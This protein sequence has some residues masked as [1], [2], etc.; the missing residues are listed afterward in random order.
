M[1]RKLSTLIVLAAVLAIS[2]VALAEGQH[3]TRTGQAGTALKNTS[4]Q[5]RERCPEIIKGVIFYRHKTWDKQDLLGENRTKKSSQYVWSM[6]CDYAEWVRKGWK[7]RNEIA[8]KEVERR[9]L[10]NSNDWN[11][12]IRIVQRAFPGTS[13]WMWSCSGAEGGHGEWVLYGGRPYY[14]GAEYAKTFHGWMVGGPMQYMWP[15]FK[16]HYRN[17]LESLKSRGFLVDLPPPSDVQAWR[18]MLAQAIAAGWAKWS[19]NDGSHWSASS[20][21]GC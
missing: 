10:P 15:T 18:S 8:K 21:N 2:G 4:A 7:K 1:L 17:G 9:T 6:G 19:G 5:T 20:S 13:G 16:G 3:E 14:P 12:S 11:T